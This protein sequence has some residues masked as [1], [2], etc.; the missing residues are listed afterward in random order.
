MT[1]RE[2]PPCGLYRTLA[3]IGG[4]EAG[5]LVYFHN[6]GD[7]G[8]GVY[9][10]E[11]WT[12][13]RAHWSARGTTVPETFDGKALMPLPREGFYR[14]ARSFHCC[15]KKCVEFAPESFVQLGYNG[16]GE[17]LL[18]V[19]EVVGGNLDIPDRGTRLD[20]KVLP[21]LIP[22]QVRER[23]DARDDLPPFPRSLVIH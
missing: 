6:H 3:P 5:R 13:N 21:N 14:V 22:L 8:P 10:P 4:I 11:R 16:K 23:N 18:F 19:P 7:P 9:L 2:L 12:R 17:P 15:D 20:D 1:T